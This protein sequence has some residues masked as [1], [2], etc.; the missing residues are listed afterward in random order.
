MPTRSP[1]PPRVVTLLRF[2]NGNLHQDVDELILDSLFPEFDLTQPP[3]PEG[4]VYVPEFIPAEDEAELIAWIDAQPWETELARRRQFYGGGYEAEDAP[5]PLPELLHRLGQRM[6]SEGL[7]PEIPDR[8][9]INEY[10]PGQGIAAHVDHHPRFGNG[11][12]IVSLLDSY[13]MRF[14]QMAGGAAFEQWL[15][16]RS[17][18]VLFGP[19]RYLWT[20]EITKRHSDMVPGGGKRLRGRRLSVTFRKRTNS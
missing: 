18:C 17:A 9:L 2:R 16:R 11:V 5:E 7:L 4:L 19:S 20:H 15:E 1:R 8:V 10:L 3:A 6:H 12:G 13:P 14:V